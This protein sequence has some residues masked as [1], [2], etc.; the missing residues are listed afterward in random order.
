MS[1]AAVSVDIWSLLCPV[2]VAAHQPPPHFD[3]VH[4][5]RVIWGHAAGGEP[6]Q[7]HRL[8]LRPRADQGHG[9]A[10]AKLTLASSL[11]SLPR[12]RIRPL[13]PQVKAGFGVNLIGVA[14]VML[15]ITTWGVPL[16][17]LTEFPAWAV[18][19]NV[20]GIL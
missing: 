7:R 14:V 5:V 17:N 9:T 4:H 15:A 11:S 20:T 10:N 13:V 1:H 2:G 18:T 16:F 6:P 8:Q 12:H 19:P 3:P